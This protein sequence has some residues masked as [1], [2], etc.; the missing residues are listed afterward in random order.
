MSAPAEQVAIERDLPSS[1]LSAQNPYPGLSPFQEGDQAFFFGREHEKVEVFRLIRRD[2][3]T[4][5]FDRSGL[6]KTSL[7]RAG[8]FPLLR[9]NFFLPIPIRLS[10]AADAPALIAQIKRTVSDEIASQQWMRCSPKRM[11]PCGN[12]STRRAFGTQRIA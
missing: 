9:D 6:G 8:V 4:V 3:L 10:F 7:L 5:L 2:V 11:R 1:Q 12:T